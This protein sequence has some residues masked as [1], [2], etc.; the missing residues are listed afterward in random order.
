MNSNLL[1]GS[2]ETILINLLNE[3]GEMYGYEISKKVKELSGE[4]IKLTEGALYPILHKMEGTGFL[5]VDTRLEKNRY[6]KYYSITQKGK[7]ILDTY[8]QDMQEYL[9][10]MNTMLYQKK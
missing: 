5:T 9:F 8:L 7:S 2:L 10:V 1:R 3:H 4:K 6:R